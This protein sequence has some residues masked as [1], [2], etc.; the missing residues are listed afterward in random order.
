MATKT[1]KVQQKVAIIVIKRIAPKTFFLFVFVYFVPRCKRGKLS[2]DLP[3]R[4]VRC[5]NGTL[6]ISQVRKEDSDVYTCSAKSLLGK[7]EK[8]TMLVVVSLPR[9]TSKSPSKILSMLSSTVNLNCSATGDPQPIISWRK[10]GGQLPVGRSQEINGTLVITN[11]QQSDS[12]TYI[13]TATSAGVFIV[14]TVSNLEMQRGGMMILKNFYE[15]SYDDHNL[16]MMSCAFSLNSDSFQS[17]RQEKLFPN[18]NR[19]HSDCLLLISCLPNSQDS[20]VRK[21]CHTVLL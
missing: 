16:R 7:V 21:C 4:R 17:P 10:E 18:F 19:R 6:Q 9:F 12:G 5:N 2:R 8:K 1:L 20:G 3:L 14:E 11:I 13:C 15:S